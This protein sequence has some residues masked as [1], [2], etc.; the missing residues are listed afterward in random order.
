MKPGTVKLYSG[1]ALAVLVAALALISFVWTPYDVR[2]IDIAQRLMGLSWTH[3][4]GTDVLGRDVLSLLMWGGRNSLFVALSAVAC[5]AL[6]GLP[7]GLWA[8]ARGGFIDQILM[9]A[10]DIVFA[11]PAVLLAVLLSASLGPGAINAVLAIGLFNIPVFAR[12][13]RG[14]ALVQWQQPYVL[15]ARVA[16]K[17]ALRISWEHI[18]PN[19]A[20]GVGAQAAIQFSMAIVA[21]AGLSYIGLGVQP[22]APSWGRMLSEAQTLIDIAPHLALFPGL[23]IFAAVLGFNLL[24]EGLSERFAPR[25]QQ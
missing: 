10:S 15:A 21:E 20:V 17:N 3:P 25:R 19:I 14:L 23:A 6:I 18:L 16:G 8:A 1:A 7:I 13:A 11:F 9:R 24:G 12:V 5:G 4:F 22:P 2:S